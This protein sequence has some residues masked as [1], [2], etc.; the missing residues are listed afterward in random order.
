MEKK[1]NQINI[2]KELK[3]HKSAKIP[4]ESTILNNSLF[5]DNSDN[6]SNNTNSTTCEG[7][8]K[9]KSN[10]IF[11]YQE[12]DKF[13]SFC[14]NESNKDILSAG[15]NEKKN[16]QNINNVNNINN[17]NN[18]INDK[19]ESKNTSFSYSLNEFL[20]DYN[21]NNSAKKR[22]SAFDSM[23]PYFAQYL[24]QNFRIGDENYFFDQND[25]NF[26]SNIMN[27]QF[28]YEIRRTNTE[29]Q[30]KNFINAFFN[31]F[32]NLRN[33]K[34]KKY[35]E[36]RRQSQGFIPIYNYNGIHQN[37]GN[38][39]NYNN[40]FYLNNAFN[41]GGE[42]QNECIQSIQNMPG[43]Q[44]DKPNC[45]NDNI[46]MMNMQ[47]INEKRD[48]PNVLNEIPE[49]FRKKSN[50]LALKTN[51]LYNQINQIKLNCP[52]LSNN[53]KFP[54]NPNI[55]SKDKKYVNNN[56]NNNYSVLHIFQDQSNCRNI[57]EQLESH[58]NDVKYIKNFLE[59]IKPD[60]VN[61][62]EH[63]F[64]NYVI[65]KLLEILIYQENKQLIKEFI[66]AINKNDKFYEITVNNYG[67]RVIQK[68]LEKLID[69]NN[70]YSKIE[71]P[72]L[73]N[74]FVELIRKH[75]YDLC[76]DKNGNHVYQK[77]LKVFNDENKNDFLY[78]YLA[79]IS[80]DIALL[81]QG[82]TIFTTAFTLSNYHQK[83]KISK[84]IIE[85][86]DKLINDKYGNYSLQ[87]IIKKLENEKNLIEPIYLYISDNIVELSKQ[88][89]SS[90][91]IDK[92]IM[93][94]DKY[95]KMLV[96]DMIK[97]NIIKDIIKDQYGNYVVQKALSISDEKTVHEII[98]EI[99]PIVPEL[100]ESN[101]GKKIYEKLSQQYNDI[102]S[103]E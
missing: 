86:I 97:K 92:F 96:N 6:G 2:N 103:Q 68:T 83:E 38:V 81:Q 3:R 7:L 4:P 91:V 10:S 56:F 102:F 39:N 87:A 82:A 90:N 47:S 34:E 75:L 54:L 37:F 98:K 18:D 43:I 94:K 58:K 93:K 52:Y 33:N 21:M 50:S 9:I 11:A 100:L 45:Q 72:E 25:N 12:F 28:P 1:Q 5:K 42:R 95:S 41:P 69:I 59:E 15:Q 76:C 53:I 8:F 55:N 84:N 63:Q 23:P 62:I 32:N 57:Q 78:D 60:L 31:Q 27:S 71:G 74:C 88:K 73:T 36:N 89:Y 26:F 64:G 22:K 67:T 65:Q 44:G 40:L 20:E 46:N 85:N 13:S 66:L 35:F 49:N 77:L 48:F 19:D 16:I 29:K 17:I 101:I 79:K 99:K 70:S 61:I 51:P 30:N 24:G 14:D 80:L